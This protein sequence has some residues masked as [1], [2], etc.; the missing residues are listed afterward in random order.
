MLFTNKMDPYHLRRQVHETKLSR[1]IR[2][3]AYILVRG[4]QGVGR[5]IVRKRR[6][7]SARAVAVEQFF[8]SK[9]HT[10]ESSSRFHLKYRRRCRVVT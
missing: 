1:E 10:Y 9:G 5:K 2:R 7:E 4:L 6:W 3:A 8:G